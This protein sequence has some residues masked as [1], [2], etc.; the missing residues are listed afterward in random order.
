LRTAAHAGDEDAEGAVG[1][2]VDSSNGNGRNGGD[3]G[4]SD[5]GGAHPTAAPVQAFALAVLEPWQR[6]LLAIDD[7]TQLGHA[8]GFIQG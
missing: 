6:R 3:A 7:A 4:A 5:A 1:A 2:A 8:N